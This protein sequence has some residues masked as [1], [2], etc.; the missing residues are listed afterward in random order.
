MKQTIYLI[1]ILAATISA[2]KK[3]SD[4]APPSLGSW[5]FNGGTYDAVACTADTIHA[6]LTA[7]NTLTGDPYSNI[8]IY[9]YDSLPVRT[10]SFVV[11]RDNHLT[12]ANQ[13]S[14]TVG[15]MSAGML[16]YYA[17]LGLHNQKVAV[18]VSAGKIAVTGAAIS[19]TKTSASL[20]TIPLSFNI[21]QAQ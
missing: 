15:Y 4:P 8:T 1:L 20:D 14:I 11:A 13:I 17:T 21:R 10:D 5:T 18:T 3:T 7:Y 16:A 2:C 12:A 19:I 9:F 6:T